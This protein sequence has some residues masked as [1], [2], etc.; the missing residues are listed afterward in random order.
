MTNEITNLIL[1]NKKIKQ[2]Q[3]RASEKC[4]QNEKMREK[5]DTFSI[6]KKATGQSNMSRV[7]LSEVK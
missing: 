5:H 2:A 4:E 6:H 7:A 1:I 3:Q